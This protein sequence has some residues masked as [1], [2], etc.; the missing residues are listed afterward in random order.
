M[1]VADFRDY[2]ESVQAFAVVTLMSFPLQ[3]RHGDRSRVCFV[4]T[5]QADGRGPPSQA[6][7]LGVDDAFIAVFCFLSVWI[8]RPGEALAQ[9]SLALCGEFVHNSLLWN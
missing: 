8:G 3:H 4:S 5:V 1:T 7:A 6:G 9:D 2:T